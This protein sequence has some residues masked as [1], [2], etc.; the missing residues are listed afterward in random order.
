M[1]G[2]A[3]ATNHPAPPMFEVALG[4]CLFEGDNET[5]SNARRARRKT[6]GAS[7]AIEGLILG[8][9]V[10]APLLTK[11]AQPQLRRL[12]PPPLAFFGPWHQQTPVQHAGQFSAARTPSIANPFQPVT[13]R[14]FAR[15]IRDETPETSMAEPLGSIPEDEIRI[16]G[17]GMAPPIVVPPPSAAPP[18]PPEKH[19]LKLSEGVLK[20]QLVSQIE[21]RY[22]PL[23][24]QTKTAGIVVLHAIISRD[25]RITSLSVL[26]GHPLLVQAAL[27]A[28]RQ[29]RYRPTMLNGEPVEVE[30]TITV[31]FHLRE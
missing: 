10:A 5:T 14:L 18:A 2:T 27:E 24:V 8:L 16:A 15:E 25:G 26:S 4:Q 21:P 6:F 30:S 13:P 20:A 12:L 22:P 17:I 29:W 1:Q 7:L 3:Q 9:L 31:I 11:V 19:P 23:A 28:V